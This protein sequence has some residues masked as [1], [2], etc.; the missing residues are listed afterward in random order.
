MPQY[1]A[2]RTKDELNALLDGKL[3]KEGLQLVEIFMRR[4]DA[5]QALIGQAEATSKLNA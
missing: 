2:V 4:G 1:H 5:P 3:G